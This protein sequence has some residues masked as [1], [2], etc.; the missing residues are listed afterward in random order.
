MV[1]GN[2]NAQ[3][4]DLFTVDTFLQ[5]FLPELYT[6]LDRQSD[7]L[8]EV[9]VGTLKV[10]NLHHID[11]PTLRTQLVRLLS[12]LLFNFLLKPK[13]IELLPNIGLE[14]G[15][16]QQ[17][18]Q[19][20]V[21]L[22][23]QLEVKNGLEVVHAHGGLNAVEQLVSE[24]IAVQFVPDVGGDGTLAEVE[25]FTEG[26]LAESIGEVLD[27]KVVSCYFFDGFVSRV[28]VVECQKLLLI[29]RSEEGSTGDLFVKFLLPLYV[30]EFLHYSKL[31][32]VTKLMCPFVAEIHR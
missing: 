17:L 30:S 2:L 21:L 10:I 15:A 3:A 29:I 31:Q 5:Y 9:V 4:V 8:Q 32:F 19:R 27:F 24:Y 28:D 14:L 11:G 13:N 7:S 20:L 25:V 6:G 26:V 16:L 1:F 12:D 23:H 18:K 22:V